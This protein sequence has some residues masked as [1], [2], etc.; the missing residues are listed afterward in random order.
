MY[1][2]H[3]IIEPLVEELD[4]NSRDTDIDFDGAERDL[5]EDNDYS[6]EMMDVS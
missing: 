5:E 6:V 2:T 1:P 3:I 4:C